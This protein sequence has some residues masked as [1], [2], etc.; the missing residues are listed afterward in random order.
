[1]YM[2]VIVLPVGSW[3][4]DMALVTEEKNLYYTDSHQNTI[5]V[6]SLETHKITILVSVRFPTRFAIDRKMG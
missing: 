6:L 4:F 5:D 2:C 3:I 1:M